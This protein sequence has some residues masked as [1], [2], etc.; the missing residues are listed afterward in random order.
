MAMTIISMP[1]KISLAKWL[2]NMPRLDTMPLKNMAQCGVLQRGC[3]LDKKGGNNLSL[4]QANSSL[5]TDNII[6]G[7]SFNNAMQAPSII[8]TDQK[9][10][11]T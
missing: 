9:G 8:N 7:K 1:K 6:E 2:P 11:N 4:D 10:G 5:D 3:I